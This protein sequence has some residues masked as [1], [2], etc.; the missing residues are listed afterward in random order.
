MRAAGQALRL[1][2]PLLLGPATPRAALPGGARS[3]A[4]YRL[5]EPWLSCMPPEAIQWDALTHIATSSP[6][7]LSNY[8]AICNASATE[9]RVSALAK[10][11][12]VRTIWIVDESVFPDGRK[13]GG[14][15]NYHRTEMRNST[16][17]PTP[18]NSI[19][20]AAREC[21]VDGIEPSRPTAPTRAWR[22][23][24]RSCSSRTRRWRASR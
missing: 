15:T 20:Q 9:K 10:A 4:W 17:R 6:T 2:L 13:P 7:V 22:P 8:T 23:S 16:Q 3:F 24:P 18:I 19:G 1:L 11:H 14:G 5:A 21:G 12:G